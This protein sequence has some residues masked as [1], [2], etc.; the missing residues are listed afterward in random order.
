[1]VLLGKLVIGLLDVTSRSISGNA[2]DV[3]V[4]LCKDLYNHD[5]GLK[6]SSLESA[7]PFRSVSM[8]TIVRE[9]LWQT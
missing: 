4:V 2:K 7:M 6:L 8:Q 3:I 5:T 1:M 9:I